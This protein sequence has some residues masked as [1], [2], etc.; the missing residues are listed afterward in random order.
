MQGIS[1]FLVERHTR[2]SP[3]MSI[4]ESASKKALERRYNAQGKL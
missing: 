2:P 4:V 1:L 3:S